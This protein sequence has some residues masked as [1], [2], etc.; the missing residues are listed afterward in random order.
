MRCFQD[1][2]GMLRNAAPDP[3]HTSVGHTAST[4]VTGRRLT[5]TRF[6]YYGCSTMA[7]PLA[8]QLNRLQLG[9]IAAARL[10]YLARRTQHVSPLLHELDWL[11][12]TQRIEL[13]LAVLAYRCLNGTVQQY[14]ADGLQR[15][16]D[17][18]SLSRLRSASTAVLHI[19]R[20][21]HK[22]IDDRAFPVTAAKVWNSAAIDN[23]VAPV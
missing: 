8:R 9:L 3:K 17:I 22:T 5:L 14:L 12:V 4:P 16:A 19:P 10:V 13:H 7:G 20:S 23:V 1:G 6:D 2:I 18:S 15:V 21:N 11:R